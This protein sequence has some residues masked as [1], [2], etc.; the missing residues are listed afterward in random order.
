MDREAKVH[1]CDR[2]EYIRMYDYGKKIYYCD[3]PDRIDDMGKLGVEELPENSPEWCPLKCKGN[4]NQDSDLIKMKTD[5]QLTD[6]MGNPIEIKVPKPEY[7]SEI[8]S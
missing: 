6:R 5:I 7:R 3:H 8:F 1:N 4:R 2:C